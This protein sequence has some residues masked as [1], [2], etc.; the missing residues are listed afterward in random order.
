MLSEL[1][2]EAVAEGLLLPESKKNIEALL[3][4]AP[5]KFYGDVVC[6]LAQAGHWQELNDR[7]FRTLSFG[8]GGLRGRTIG[9]VVAELERGDAKE[10][11]APRHP[12]VGT[13]AMN[14][15]NVRRATRGLAAYV[16]DYFLREGRTGRPRVVV[17]YDTRH[18]SRAFAE[19]AAKVLV[20]L[21][22][23][24]Y[25]FREPRSTPQLSYAVRYYGA[26]AGV[27]ITASHNPPAYN[28]YKVY[29]EDGGQIV[30]PHASGIIARVNAVVGE[31]H[32]PVPDSERGHMVLV[33]EELD[34]DYMERLKGLVVE[35]EVLREAGRLRVVYTPLHGV[36]GAIIEP[37]LRRV[38]VQVSVVEAQRKPDGN[39]STVA[40]PNPEEQEALSMAIGQAE[41]EGADL[42]IGT[43]PDA[44]RMGVAV[45]DG[46]GRMRVLT[47]NQIGT[48]MAWHRISR[49]FDLNILNEGNRGRAVLI[50]TYVTTDLQKAIAERY[51]VR[52]VET[53]TGFKYI[54][55]KMTKY[56]LALPGGIRQRY[57]KM[58][59]EE[60]RRVMLEQST[61]FVFG[62]EESYGYSGGDFVRDK[63]ANGAA[64]M[65]VEVALYA[66]REG[67][68]LVE[69]L[70]RIYREYG[71]YLERGESLTMEGAD[72]AR[73]I[74]RL[75]ESYRAEP[76][77]EVGGRLVKGVRDFGKEDIWDTEGD[78]L[79]KEAMLVWEL[80]G[81]YRVAVRPSGTEP[82]IKYYLFGR[83]E[84]GEGE[85]VEA[86]WERVSGELE[87][88]W[89]GL[90]G[91]A[92]ARVG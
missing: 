73:R 30:E 85:T 1:L 58:G 84:V 23:D 70:E 15:Y 39:F 12:C 36:G 45:R 48:L 76:P 64:L 65:L 69:L 29:F 34:Y 77:R 37:L 11:E 72:G 31:L 74:G 89:V 83:E 21:G 17:C 61:Y 68:T 82:K 43:D 18:F 49:L 16:W 80:E 40:S 52:C 54:G 90:K 35:P 10:G 71:F 26:Q 27:N 63:D 44:D 92:L 67:M 14:F 56:E 59:V 62:G 53:L 50:K 9:R 87:R 5:T 91:D 66:R 8:T 24:A 88:M 42:V 79:P 46:R 28:G 41:G 22:C 4:G 86:V 7:F 47:G 2:A 13:N 25:L 51:G 19:L 75:V 3:Q 6:E 81:G 33:G 32:T 20:E 57:P 60:A 38:G 78:L 55:A